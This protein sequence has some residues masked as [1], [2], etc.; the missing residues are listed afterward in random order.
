MPL[1][2][3]DKVMRRTITGYAWLL[4]TML[5]LFGFCPSVLGQTTIID[6]ETANDGYSPSSTSGSGNTDVFNRTDVGAGGNSTFYWAVEDNPLTNPSITLDQIDITGATGFTFSIDLLAHHYN[7][8]DDSDEL[9]ITYS[10]DGGPS[11]DLLWVQNAGG[12]FNEAAAI[13]TDFDG[14]GEC[15]ASTTLPALTTGNSGCNVTSSNFQT[16]STNSISLSGNTTLDITLQFNALTSADEGIYLDNIVITQSSGSPDPEP[17]NH[18]TAFAATVNSASQITLDWTD[19]T[20]TNL[21]AGYLILANQ[22]G[23]FTDPVDGTAQTND[24]DLSDGSAA[25]NVNQ[26]VETYAFTGLNAS[27]QYY[28]KIFPYS[29]SGSDIDYKVDGTPETD[30]AT[31]QAAVPSVL[32][33]LVFNEVLPDPNGSNNFDTDGDGNAETDDE[34]I[35]IY[36]TSGSSLDISGLE[37]WDASGNFYTIP[38]S[39]TLGANGFVVIVSDVAGGS[40]PTVAAGSHAFS[41]SSDMSLSNGGEDF[42]LYDPTTDEYI[43]AVYNGATQNDPTNDYTGFSATAAR[44]GSVLAFG[45]YAE[46]VSRA[47]SP[48]GDINSIVD[49]N[50]IGSGNVLATPGASNIAPV[51]PEPTNHPTAFAATV[52]GI[53]QITVNWTD[54]STGQLPASYLVMVNE[55]GTFPDPVDGTAQADDTD[56]SDGAGVVNVAQGVQT[57]TFNGLTDN[58]QYFFKIFPYTNTGSNVDY[59]TDGT[60]ETDDAT[61]DAITVINLPVSEDFSNCGNLSNWVI[62]SVDADAGSTWSCGSGYVEANAFGASAAGN[63][64][65]IL[66]PI[67]FDS[68][69]NEIMSFE[70]FTEFTD[71]GQPNPQITVQYSTNYAGSGDPSSATWTTLN[72]FT[73]P[74][75]NSQQFTASGSVS[76]N[77]ISGSEVYIAF[78]YQ[79]SGTGGGSTTRWRV[80]NIDI[81]EIAPEPTNH[82]TGFAATANGTTQITVDWTDATGTQVPDGYLIL[83]N[84]T[85]TFTAPVDGTAQTDDSDLSD[86]AAAVNVSQGVETFAFSGLTA[87]TQYFFTIYPYTNSGVNIDYKTDGTPATA[88]ATTDATANSVLND[89]VFNEV[90]PDPNSGSNNFDT[91]GDGSAETEDEFIEIYNTSGS[92]LDIS[93]LEFWDNNNGN[94]FTVP[95][96][97]TLGANG[98]VVVVASVA[99]GS[100]PSVGAGSHA[101]EATGS[102]SLTNNGEDFVLYDPAT[103]QFI[104]AVYNGATQNDPASDYT[105]FSATATLIGSVLD[106]GSDT[107]GVS[108]ALSPDGDVAN[109][110]QHNTI[111]SGTVLATP[112]ASNIAAD[113]TWDGTA[114]DPAGTPGANDD[115]AIVGDYDVAANGNLT[116]ADL[117]IANGATLSMTS[118]SITIGGNL[119][120]NGTF[121]QTGGSVTFDGS[122]A[123]TINGDIT[124]F[125]LV[126]DNTSGISFSAGTDVTILSSITLTNGTLTTAS[127]RRLILEATAART[128]EVIPGNGSISGAF[129]VVRQFI[130][131]GL[132]GVA[133]HHLSS[134]VSGV[135]Y[136]NLSGPG[137]TLNLANRDIFNTNPNDPSLAGN[138]FPNLFVYNSAEASNTGNIMDGWECPAPTVTVTPGVG[139]TVNMDRSDN[140]GGTP[141]EL[142]GTLNDG[143]ITVNNVNN[144]AANPASNGLGWHLLGNPYPSSLSISEFFNDNAGDI[145]QTLYVFRS[146]GSRYEGG[147]ASRTN[148]GTTAGTFTLGTHIAPMQAFFVRSQT[149]S[150]SVNFQNDQRA[151]SAGDLNATFNRTEGPSE[152]YEGVLQLGIRPV[153]NPERYSFVTL[154]L[155]PEATAGYDKGHEAYLIQYNPQGWPTMHFGQ[156][157][158]GEEQNMIIKALPTAQ[159]A[160]QTISES[161]QI[162]TSESGQMQI[163]AAQISHFAQGATVILEDKQEGI[164]HYFAANPTYTFQIEEG[165]HKDRFVVHLQNTYQTPTGLEEDLAKLEAQGIKVSAANNAVQVVFE[166][167]NEA[168]IQVLDITGRELANAQAHQASLELPVGEQ[169]AVIVRIQTAE[170]LH[171]VKLLMNNQ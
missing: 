7:D 152:H 108:L 166:Q 21:P 6:F 99:G 167:A 29:N 83:A 47:L 8:W 139:F 169:A 163:E 105:G 51:D 171:I 31:T 88:N 79:S 90:L 168:Q 153:A 3:I 156:Q 14:D 85:G 57:Y 103:D 54:A 120:N 104:Q 42:V 55:S 27:T 5:L 119:T 61:T 96:G 170:G 132:D 100:L 10:V 130:D 46:G 161:L 73:F 13:D 9:L 53:T 142:T 154:A 129:V 89:L 18:P 93:G 38:A 23:T 50:A 155:H 66:P 64:W 12:Q 65:I 91:D 68:Y 101:F 39:T 106:F 158:N 92:S 36:N 165:F 24:T 11:Q 145:D 122:A 20:G 37:L 52:D 77:A 60:P 69:S 25:V 112:G 107:D 160:S 97:T 30:D 150:G 15:G 123:Q 19:A 43:Q 86:G 56:L 40:L 127:G 137:F 48:D 159:D 121:T 71:G 62:Y 26:G 126:V 114:W 141:V 17:D 58:T 76:L 116:C 146:S 113:F 59:K 74:A 157:A 1:L 34:F 44:I 45:N 162:W 149:A 143:N 136:Q 131:Q 164:K 134:P 98:Y 84:Q 147:Y 124:F 4:S 115:V 125:D 87:A 135:Q 144:T 2:K 41:T 67:D 63:D 140:H 80:D 82:P 133:Y 16:F 22:T 128:A 117:N 95:N 102:M 81:R 110:V 32:N 70:S 75:S 49:H 109:P 148:G 33:D 28:F 118:G 72:G 151:T 94:F 78:Q 35:E 111:G 138:N